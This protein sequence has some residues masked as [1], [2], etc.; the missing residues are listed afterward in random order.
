[1]QYTFLRLHPKKNPFMLIINTT[2]NVSQTCEEDWKNWV[3]MEYIP[4]VIA[5]GILVKPHFFRLLIENEPGSQSYA[6]QFEVENLDQLER[7]FQEYGTDLQKNMSDLFQ[8]KVLGFTT[9][10]ESEDTE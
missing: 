2:Y 8:E 1:M 4:I 5:P 3:R 10:M 7:W 9:L 6:L